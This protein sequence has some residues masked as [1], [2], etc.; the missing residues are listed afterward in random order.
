MKRHA[1]EKARAD[2]HA[3]K[4]TRRK[5]RAERHAQKRHAQRD[6]RAKPTLTNHWR[7]GMRKTLS[8][9]KARAKEGRATLRAIACPF[10]HVPFGRAPLW[11]CARRHAQTDS[12]QIRHVKTHAQQRCSPKHTR[13]KMRAK[14]RTPPG[15][16]ITRCRA[17]RVGAHVRVV[18]CARF[19][20]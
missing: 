14:R 1:R 16:S 12:R 18:A 20:A 7:R 5:A 4:C 19:R 9:E 15:G 11:R 13:K 2:M 3:Q 6:T 8:R 10:G 17:L